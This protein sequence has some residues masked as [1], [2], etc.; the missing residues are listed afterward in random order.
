M[1]QSADLNSVPQQVM[2]LFRAKGPGHI[3]FPSDFDDFG[4]PEAVRAALSRLVRS[5]QLNRISAGIYYYPKQHPV[6]GALLPTIDELLNAIRRHDNA[7]ILPTGQY[8]LN[9]LGLTSQVQT[10][11]VFYTSGSERRIM[12]GNRSITL[13]HIG[14]RKT[15]IQSPVCQLAVMALTTLGYSNIDTEAVEKIGQ[16][17]KKESAERIL[18]DA[19]LA[20]RWIGKIMHDHVNARQHG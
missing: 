2:D 4:S 16:A 9:K 15:A 7:T 17:L 20:P 3:A 8:A 6:F 11:D 5:G 1:K 14:S 18:Q 13:I 19:K 12:L 10:K